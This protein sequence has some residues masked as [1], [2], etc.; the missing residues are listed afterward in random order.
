MGLAAEGFLGLWKLENV[1]EA[2]VEVLE[3]G[4]PVCEPIG[5]PR[6][7]L[8]G[9]AVEFGDT[10]SELRNQRMR[11]TWK[12]DGPDMMRYLWF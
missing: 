10:I 1:V 11:S 3:S 7:R 8:G 5:G 2:V 4:Q 6:V 12:T 9:P